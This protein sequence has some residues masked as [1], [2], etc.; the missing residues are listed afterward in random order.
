MTYRINHTHTVNHSPLG[1]AAKQNTTCF[2]QYVIETSSRLELLS[3][4]LYQYIWDQVDLLNLEY[5]RN[6]VNF[7]IFA[8]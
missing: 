4:L 2:L 7:C 1:D 3:L 6:Q 5:F 8:M